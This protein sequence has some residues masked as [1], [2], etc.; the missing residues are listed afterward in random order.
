MANDGFPPTRAD[1]TNRRKGRSKTDPTEVNNTLH[2]MP[3]AADM[4]AAG[5]SFRAIGAA[6]G[7]DPTWARTLVLKAL[8]AVEVE[9]AE[10]MRKQEGESL[11]L[12]QRAV[13]PA[14]LAGDTKAVTA[15]LRIMDRRAKLF[16]LDA[17]IKVAVDADVDAQIAEL[18]ALLVIPSE[19]VT[20]EPPAT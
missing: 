8:E 10:T 15:C 6:L 13:F 14:A 5:A 7:I 17:P 2:L 18:A 20:D 3:R 19:V 12:L 16:G 1:G 9:A 11:L 4:R